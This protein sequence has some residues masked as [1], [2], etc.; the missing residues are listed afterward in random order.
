[1][2]GITGYGSSVWKASGGKA[3]AFS[4]DRGSSDEALSTG[5]SGTSE[6]PAGAESAQGTFWSRATKPG[7]GG[8]YHVYCHAV[9]VVVSGSDHRLVF[10]YGGWLVDEGAP[11]AGVSE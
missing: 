3:Q 7:M 8:G 10:S 4:G 6:C 2:A 9:G 1:M 11:H 5:L